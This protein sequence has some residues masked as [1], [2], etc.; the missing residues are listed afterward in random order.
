MGIGGVG[1]GG[2]GGMGG[3]RYRKLDMPVFEGTD[4]DGW[5]MRI[6]RYFA[7]YRL[8]E[9]EK[10]EAV[11]VAL[12]G[13]ALRWYQWENNRRP[14]RRWDELRTFMLKQFRPSSGGSLCEQ[15]LATTQL[16]TVTEYRKKFIETAA[17]LARIP[18]DILMGQFLNGLKEEIR[19]E[20]RLLNPMSLEQ[21]MELA[22]RVEEKNKVKKTGVG[23]YKSGPLSSSS[24]KYP[25]QSGS[26]GYSFQ[27][28]PTR[29]W[30]SQ[31]G[32]SQGSVTSPKMPGQS[33]Q[34]R[35]GGEM[36]RLTDKELQEKRAKGLCFRCDDKWSIG[37][38]CKKRELSVLVIEEEEDGNT[39]YSGS[40]PPLSPT[41]EQ[42]SE[43]MLQPEV[44]LNSVIGLSNPKTMKLRGRVKDREVVVMIDPGATH[45]FISLLLVELIL[46]DK[47]EIKADMLPLELGNSDIIL[48][49]QWLE[50]L[51]TVVS[52]W[53]TQ[54]MQF[55]RDGRTVTLKGDMSLVRS[56]IS[57]KAMLK[58]L[59]KEKE[60]YIIELNLVEKME[61]P[62]VGEETKHTEVPEFLK[63][64]IEK[65]DSVFETP[66]GLP[67][68]REHEHAI[69]LKEGANP[70]GV[71]PYRY[72]QCQKDEIERLIKD[73]LAAG[74]IKPSCSP[75]SSPVLLVKKRDDS[76]RFCVDYR[77]L[78]KET[79]PDKY[80]IPVIDELLDELN[81][82]TVF[83]KLDLKAGYHQIRVRPQDTHKTAF[84]THDGHYEFLVLPFG[85]MNGPA[86]FQSL[87][88]D[89]FRPFLRKFV[90][91]FFDDI[92]VYS[93]TA[94]EH[95]HH[96]ELVFDKLS[97]NRL[98]VNRKKCEFG[99]AE[100]AYLGHVISDKGVAVDG[101]KVK[102]ILDWK[103]PKN[104]KELRGFLGLTG[105]YR[106]FISKYAHKAQ[107]LTAQLK[108][109]AFGWSDA[110]TVAFNELKQAMVSSPVLVLPDFNKRFVIEA[111]ASGFGLGA[112][113]MQD[114]K[115][116][117]FFSKVLGPKS[118]LKSIYE[119]ELMA[120]CL[121]VQKW[122]YYLLGRQF[123][124]KTDQQSLR[125][126]MQQRE[127]GFEYQKWVRKLMGFSFDIQYKPG[128]SNRVA[129]ALSRKEGE[130]IEFKALMSIP[131]VDWTKLD[132]EL[133]TD[134]LLQQ[135]REDITTG[136][137]G[138]DGFSIHEGKLLYKNRLVIPRTSFFIPA[139]LK[140]YHD[141]PVGGHAG[142]V[143][144]YLRLAADWFWMGMR[145]DVTLYVQHCDICQQQK[146][147]QQVPA[148][149]LQPLPLP[150]KVWEDIS[151]DFIEGLPVSHGMDTILVVVDRLS[152]YGH[153]LA[154]KHPFTALTVATLFVK[155]IVRL[156]GFPTS[157]VS[158]RDRIFLSSFWKELFRIQGTALKRSTAYH[159]QTDGQTE[160]VNKAL[161]T[162][163]RCFAGNQP[164]SWVKWLHWAEFS[165]NTSP[166]MTT[167]H[168][169]FKIVYGRDPPLVTRVGRGQTPI[170]SIET[171]LQERDVI[172]DE[173]HV[174]LL[175][176][177]Q[178]MKGYADKN[179]REE[180]F[181]VGQKV[182]VKLQS[183]R[184]RSLARRPYEKLAAK[185]YG[186]FEI[187]QRIGQ[188]AY[189]LQLPESSKI[190]PVFHVSQ[191]KRAL[192][193]VPSSQTIPDQLTSDLELV[194]EP[195]TLLDVRR[196]QQGVEV[197]L[198]WKGLPIFEATWEEATAI[199][200]RFPDFHL[201]D[202]VKVWAPG[203]VMQGAKELI[204]Y[205]RKKRKGKKVN[206]EEEDK[207]GIE[208]SSQGHNREF[209]N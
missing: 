85:L 142:E 74:I 197:L 64:V 172:L 175:R 8:T 57:L 46:D 103:Q 185:Y 118:Q 201:E 202:K 36:R 38:R 188:V 123:L 18:E 51:G 67:P 62:A 45:N 83:S 126:L 140:L 78:N 198:K 6:E 208:D 2:T 191:L 31:S 30:V 7:F 146:F 93:K 113:L 59:Q 120:I 143:K 170:D 165:Y 90:L 77:A 70:V 124:I 194:A 22:L 98:V 157:I 43:V 4:P 158:D 91:V 190:H 125:F 80:P 11:V 87:M 28:S 178:K 167:K 137:K 186:P 199:D 161:E 181:E 55:V 160:I 48:G 110:A 179:R 153:F 114:D 60:G 81:G 23:V 56:Q 102:A 63:E 196:V 76:W 112:V 145:K 117:A 116:V 182:Y 105:Y 12:E 88:N 100:V 24:F 136:T 187:V 21:A 129:D 200:A 95:K 66:T 1:V 61:L 176:A 131:E 205:A 135:I 168:T 162:Y 171:I 154:L 134:S 96:M 41:D 42:N 26:I 58:A 128:S 34:S 99:R 148:G 139:L 189:R 15:W 138:H 84:R 50:T 82:A 19:V 53:K 75:F 174:Q 115:P 104:L 109:D 32:E 206:S 177:Q 130:N 25:S 164:K 163:L 207:T 86:T 33:N 27:S 16:T 166:H 203:N 192:G 169:P 47:V 127:I 107:P 40:D 44:S 69:V 14:I 122:R 152:K 49:V 159:P 79:V 101:E 193:P 173:L 68:I 184:Q 37:H 204:T 20:V 119:K 155:E 65:F 144:T 10:L 29:S 73:M 180:Q 111:D 106:K 9:A 195:E 5:I 209:R 121:A 150:T 39:E 132:T 94:K 183:Y 108:K 17:P 97:Q 92:L 13:D 3:W 54:L 89:V 71:R 133:S 35:T 147:S 141:S 72:P 149:L 156:H 151:L 52:N